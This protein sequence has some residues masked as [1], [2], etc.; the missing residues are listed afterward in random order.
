MGI[1]TA[2]LL[3]GVL[4]SSST[5]QARSSSG[6]SVYYSSDPYYRG[7]YYHR[8]RY[9]GGPRYRHYHGPRYYPPRYTY[10][11]GHRGYWSHREG[12]R[13]FIRIN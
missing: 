12:V 6:V 8:G 10:Y 2:L 9:Y 13:F 1:M 11:R 4:G 5:A 7:G 3:A